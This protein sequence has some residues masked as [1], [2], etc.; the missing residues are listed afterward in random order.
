MLRIEADFLIKRED[1]LT[2]E[3]AEACLCEAWLYGLYGYGAVNNVASLTVVWREFCG[4]ECTVFVRVQFPTGSAETSKVA[5][6]IVR[7]RIGPNGR[8]YGSVAQHIFI[9]FPLALLC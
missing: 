9:R 4:I 2:K 3:M 7:G 5:F 1:S 8:S 6:C